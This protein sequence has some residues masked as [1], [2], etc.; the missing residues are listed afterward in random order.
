MA[1][2]HVEFLLEPQNA[3]QSFREALRI[4]PRFVPAIRANRELYER[5][6]DWGSY[7]Q[8]LIQEADAVE[9]REAKGIALLAIG[10]DHAEKKEDLNAA[11]DWSEHALRLR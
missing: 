8:A 11:A 4:N 5:E 10:R 2:I 3:K 9:E 7:E 1:Q 6:G